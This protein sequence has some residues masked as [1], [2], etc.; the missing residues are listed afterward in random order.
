MRLISPSLH[1]VL[2]YA[3]AALLVGAPIAL[4]FEATMPAATVLSVAGGLTLLLYSLV[5][6]YSA[7][8][9]GLVP[10]RVHLALDTAAALVLLS[11]PFLLGFAGIARM[12]YLT[13]AVGVLVVVATTCLETDGAPPRERFAGATG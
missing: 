8:A 11:A 2:D 6:D 9:R 13:F 3:G 10:W 1:G 7:G 5:T 12:F 4:D